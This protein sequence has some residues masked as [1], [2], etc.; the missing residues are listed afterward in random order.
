M[1]SMERNDVVHSALGSTKYVSNIVYRPTSL[2]TM[3]VICFQGK[4]RKLPL[5]R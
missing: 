1:N 4:K 5:F 3:Y 2:Q